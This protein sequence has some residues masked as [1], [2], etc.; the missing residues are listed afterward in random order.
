MT[1]ECGALAYQEKEKLPIP[2]RCG[3]RI[4]APQ[5]G[6][7]V[8]WQTV[9]AHRLGSDIQGVITSTLSSTPQPNYREH[10]RNVYLPRL[11]ILA[12]LLI[13]Q[14]SLAADPVDTVYRLYQA[15]AWEAVI[16]GP[17]YATPFIE[18]PEAVLNQYL[19]QEL[20]V[21]LVQDREC[22]ARTEEI[23]RLDFSPLWMSQDPAAMGLT[24]VQA[25]R[26][27]EVSVS[28]RF[29]GSDEKTSMRYRLVEDSEGW[30]VSDVL[31][32]GNVSLKAL[33]SGD[34]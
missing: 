14:S 10:M 2:S 13:S 25:S 16:A 1:L 21:L 24:I 20:M 6:F 22:V 12:G 30:R 11:A 26:P 34:L 18:Q 8:N 19:T 15:F 9:C 4:L 32:E 7:S 29:P 17:D 31:Y 5:W 23:C 3:L 27:G 33:L 28:Y